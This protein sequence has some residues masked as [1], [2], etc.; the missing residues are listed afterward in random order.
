MI[1]TAKYL[2]ENLKDE[3]PKEYEEILSLKGIGTYTAS[4]ISSF[5][6]NKP[7]AVLDGNVFR[8]LSRFFGIEIPV[9][10]TSG[11]KYFEELARI[12]LDK[13]KPAEYN[14]AIMDFGAVVCK[15][16]LPLC[17][18]CPLQKKCI[19][20]LENKVSVLPVNEKKIKLKERY[21]NY[22]I[23]EFRHKFY[24]RKRIEKDI[25]N[26]LY[27]FI[28]IETQSLKNENEFLN[29]KNFLSL[30]EGNS[31]EIKSISKIYSQK[32]THQ[33]I[34]GRLFHLLLKKPLNNTRDYQM[35]TKNELKL[36]PFPKLITSYLTDKNVSLNLL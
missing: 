12:L 13:K 14:Q 26:S 5:A 31:F 19:A 23:I 6:F 9:N 7:F 25:W 15:P 27:E 32:L 18:E 35:V 36:L 24:V 10:T 2:H 21:F 4:A 16:A 17:S 33:Q 28:L 34:K 20:Y 22:L 29:S 3:F 8:V 30:L 11:K 1:A